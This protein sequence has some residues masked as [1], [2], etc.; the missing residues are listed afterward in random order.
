M[1]ENFVSRDFGGWRAQWWLHIELGIGWTTYPPLA[2]LQRS[3]WIK[4]TADAGTRAFK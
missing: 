1:V 3:D 2:S 4:C